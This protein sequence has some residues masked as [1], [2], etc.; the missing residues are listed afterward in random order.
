MNYIWA[1]AL[2]YEAS[3]SSLG[4]SLLIIGFGEFH[5]SFLFVPPFP[6]FTGYSEI[7]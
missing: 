1:I 2:N 3:S 7:I 6:S 4:F 5:K